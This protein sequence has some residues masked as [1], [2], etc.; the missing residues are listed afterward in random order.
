MHNKAYIGISLGSR[1]FSLNYLRRVIEYSRGRYEKLL[2]L[3]ADTPHVYTFMATKGISRD[4][5]LGKVRTISQ[6]K[7]KFLKGLIAKTQGADKFVELR[8]WDEIS[9]REGFSDILRGI[10]LLDEQDAGFHQDIYDTF[11]SHIKHLEYQN[12]PIEA[13]GI[14]T[15]YILEEFAIML[16]LQEW[17]D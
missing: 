1:V 5:A 14:G 13:Y 4:V 9:Q 10:Y 16:F 8:C 7:V 3:L 6:Q 15:R 12:L 17:Y 11:G 2:F